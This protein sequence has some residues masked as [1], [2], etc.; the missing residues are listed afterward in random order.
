M[1]SRGMGVAVKGLAGGL[2]AALP[3]AFLLASTPGPVSAQF[4]SDRPPPIPPA[5]VPDAPPTGPA[6]NLAPPSVP[7]SGPNLPRALN[8]LTRT[9]PGGMNH[10]SIANAPPALP[11]P[12]ATPANQA[13]LSLTAKYGKDLPVITNG[14]VWRVFADKPDDN[15]T[16]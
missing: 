4:F 10:P 11:P 3:L 2:R 14:L 12:G 9:Q 7:G 13:V 5:S 16:F 1:I 8:Q 6:M 15:G